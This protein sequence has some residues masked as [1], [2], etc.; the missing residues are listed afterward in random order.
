MKA[1]KVDSEQL[2]MKSENLLTVNCQL[3]TV[4]FLWNEKRCVRLASSLV[5]NTFGYPQQSDGE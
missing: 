4:N 5:T 3:S 1:E 2:T